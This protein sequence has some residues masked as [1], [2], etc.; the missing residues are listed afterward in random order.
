MDAALARYVLL[1]LTTNIPFLRALLAHPEFQNGAATTHFIAQHFS[2]WRPPVT[3][4]PPEA[5]IAVALHDFLSAQNGRTGAAET[6]I[7]DHNPWARTDGFRV[8]K[9]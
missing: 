9:G 3:V 5:L 4:T 1:G 2:D 7:A 8:G 6:P